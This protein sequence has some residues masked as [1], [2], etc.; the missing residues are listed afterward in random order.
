MEVSCDHNSSDSRPG[1]VTV[2]VEKDQKTPTVVTFTITNRNQTQ[3]I[4]LQHCELLKRPPGF[5]LDDLC[6]VTERKNCVRIN[7]G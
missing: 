5:Q 3:A 4:L 7:R 1:D 6:Q 2:E